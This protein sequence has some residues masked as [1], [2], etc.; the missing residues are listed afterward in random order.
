MQWLDPFRAANEPTYRCL[1]VAESWLSGPR[2]D[3]PIPSRN[4]SSMAATRSNRSA[5]LIRDRSPQLEHSTVSQPGDAADPAA[6][7]THACNR[8]GL[9]AASSARIGTSA[10]G[11][12]SG[13]VAFVV[14][15]TTVVAPTKV[16]ARPFGTKPLRTRFRPAALTSRSLE[17]RPQHRAEV[18]EH[19]VTLS[20][21]DRMRQKRGGTSV[22]H[23]GGFLYRLVAIARGSWRRSS[24]AKVT[25]A[26]V[27]FEEVGR[28]LGPVTISYAGK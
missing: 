28:R 18:G 21:R 12:L 25:R 11:I 22:G 13:G 7:S 10:G 24:L 8:S 26:A 23:R 17:M 14:A 15:V 5:S 1:V 16:S 3:G 19:L 20:F 6:S 2:A 9:S 27:G 4:N